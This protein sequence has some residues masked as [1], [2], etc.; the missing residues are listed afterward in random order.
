MASVQEPGM[1]RLYKLAP[2]GNKTLIAQDRTEAF[3]PAGG[4]PDAAAASVATPEKWVVID[5]N[6]ILVNDDILLVTLE[7]DG[8]DT[9]DA[10]DSIWRIP[11]VTAAGTKS[12]GNT[13]FA[14]PALSDQAMVAGKESTVAGYKIVESSARLSG[15]HF[16]DFQDDT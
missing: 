1:V 5:S 8:A 6:V 15:R 7:T 2:S 11:L 3:A 16:Q 12:L 14:N 4:A 13:Q 10:S 9:L